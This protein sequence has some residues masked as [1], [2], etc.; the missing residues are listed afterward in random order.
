MSSTVGRDHLM[1][2]ITVDRNQLMMNSTV[3]KGL[4]SETKQFRNSFFL[5]KQYATGINSVKKLSIFHLP[6]PLH[7]QF[8]ER[9]SLSPPVPPTPHPLI[10]MI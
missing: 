5:S 6:M 1:V 4:T 7:P 9:A 8:A 2:K 10:A 3:D